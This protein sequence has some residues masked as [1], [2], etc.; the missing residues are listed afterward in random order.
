MAAISSRGVSAASEAARRNALRLFNI[1]AIFADGLD[2]RPQG[3][4]E[5]LGES[6][7]CNTLVWEKIAIACA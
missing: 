1:F 7:R 6:D 3:P 5:S 4:L 2:G